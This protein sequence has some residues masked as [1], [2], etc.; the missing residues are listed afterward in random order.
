MPSKF[1]TI[2][3]AD[4]RWIEVVGTVTKVVSKKIGV[5]AKKTLVK[6]SKVITPPK[7]IIPKS[8]QTRTTKE[9]G[10]IYPMLHPRDCIREDLRDWYDKQH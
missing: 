5:K 1:K 6:K 2:N 10:T 8:T 4:D 7:L 3:K 9:S